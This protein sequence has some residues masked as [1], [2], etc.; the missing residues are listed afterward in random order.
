MEAQE[1]ASEET[2]LQPEHTPEPVRAGESPFIVRREPSAPTQRR[3]GVGWLLAGPVVLG[4]VLGLPW[5][6]TAMLYEAAM[7][8]SVLFGTTLLMLP[9]LYIGATILGVA[10]SIHVVLRSFGRGLTATGSLLLGFSPLCAFLLLTNPTD[11]IWAWLLGAGTLTVSLWIGLRALQE[12]MFATNEKGYLWWPLFWGWALVALL[13]GERL[14]S[15]SFDFIT[16]L[17]NA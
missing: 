7:L 4:A 11:V 2:L 10:P 6:W 5:G 12:E 17:S 1:T 3:L 14:F 13:I 16:A 8:P 9:A 15:Q